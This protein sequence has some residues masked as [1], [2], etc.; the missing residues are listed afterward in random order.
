MY[1]HKQGRL[2]MQHKIDNHAAGSTLDRRP[3]RVL[4]IF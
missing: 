2:R 1:L 4:H 3:K